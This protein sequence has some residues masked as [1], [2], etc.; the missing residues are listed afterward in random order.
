MFIPLS[1][2]GALFH[3]WRWYLFQSLIS[4]FRCT[5]FEVDTTLLSALDESAVMDTSSDFDS[6]EP[7]PYSEFANIE[8][9]W[10]RVKSSDTE[11]LSHASEMYATGGA[12]A[13][14]YAST[15]IS[16]AA[17]T[18]ANLWRGAW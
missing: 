6:D 5:E 10:E 13:P 11:N 1:C 16:S 14:V 15:L 3:T 18:V 4:Y 9:E 7:T 2:Y 12:S 17:S 8:P